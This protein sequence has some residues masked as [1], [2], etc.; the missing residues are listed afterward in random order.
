[1]SE[2]VIRNIESIILFAGKRIVSI[3]IKVLLAS[4]FTGL[5]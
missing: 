3:T 2:T 5:G 4:G 1:M